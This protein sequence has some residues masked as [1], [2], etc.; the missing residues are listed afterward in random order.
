MLG[1]SLVRILSFPKGLGC[2]SVVQCFYRIQKIQCLNRERKERRKMEEVVGK[3]KKS[4]GEGKI[5]KEQVG[6][7]RDSDNTTNVVMERVYEGIHDRV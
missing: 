2:I 1:C 3:R 6:K 4:E 5:R 7:R